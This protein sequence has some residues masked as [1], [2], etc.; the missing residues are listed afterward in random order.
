MNT[1]WLKGYTEPDIVILPPPR[2]DTPTSPTSP[3]TKEPIRDAPRKFSSFGE[4][5]TDTRASTS[6]LPR[7][8]SSTTLDVYKR[9]QSLQTSSFSNLLSA[10]EGER[11]CKEKT[12]T[13]K[14]SVTIP[15]E[16]SSSKST[17]ELPQT[18][19]STT[20]AHRLSVPQ[21]TVSTF[22]SGVRRVT[23]PNV[24][25]VGLGSSS[26]AREPGDRKVSRTSVTSREHPL[27]MTVAPLDCRNE[28]E[29]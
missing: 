16:I 7:G 24:E 28:T 11:L 8:L 27:Q 29:L 21:T 10:E 23:Q 14:R 25:T 1:W 9:H 5:Y 3:T 4:K 18:T 15:R 13:S 20:L 22:A 17:T 2:E 19:Q 6:S 12:A 26:R